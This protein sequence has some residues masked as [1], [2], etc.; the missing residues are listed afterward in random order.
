[1]ENKKEVVSGSATI[2]VMVILTILVIVGTTA[3]R[4]ATLLHELAMQR[5]LTQ[6][7]FRGIEALMNYGIAC[8]WLI[9]SSKKK[10]DQYIYTF[11]QWPPNTGDYSG[12]ITISRQKRLYTVKGQLLKEAQEVAQSSCHVWPE[13]T[14]W[15]TALFEG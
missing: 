6:K 14:E 4:T 7:Q 8:C 9:D 3:L 10:E 12:K 1:M 11:D 2:M 5:V 15:K 13:K